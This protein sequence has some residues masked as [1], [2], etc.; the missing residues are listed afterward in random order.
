[1]SAAAHGFTIHIS[2]M[3]KDNDVRLSSSR[4]TKLL[5]FA[6]I[7]ITPALT[8]DGVKPVTDINDRI[9][10]TTII[11]DGFGLTLSLFSSF[12]IVKASRVI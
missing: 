5:N 7:C 10:H 12:W 8:T 6:A 2:S 9:K 4:S 11:M 1:M 3:A